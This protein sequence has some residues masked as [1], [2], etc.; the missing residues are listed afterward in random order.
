MS[1]KLT[2]CEIE[3]LT[4]WI[5]AEEKHGSIFGIP[6]EL[7]FH[8][9]ASDPFRLRRY[10]QILETPIG[11]AAGPH[12][13][14]SQNII[15]AWLTGARY[16]ELKT[17]QVLDE[18]TVTKPCIDMR[19]EGYNCEW[20]QE[21]KLEASYSEYLNAWIVLHLLRHRFFGQNNR[22]RGFIFNLSVGYNLEG[23]LSPPVQLF[24]DRMTDCRAEKTDRIQRLAGIYPA[25]AELEI[26]D[27][28][29]DNITIST[30]HGCPP[31]E[32][33]KI[34][35]YF[36]EERRLN[37]TIKLNPTLLGADR[38]RDIL[39]HRLGFDIVVPDAAFAHDPTFDAGVDLIRN[40][41]AS[42][43]KAGVTFN[44]KL[45][46]TLETENRKGNLPEN[47]KMLYMSGRALHAISI[48]LAARLQQ[49]FDGQLD[50]SFSAGVDFQNVARVLACGLSP[51][52]VCTDIL[53]PG[54]YGRLQ[55][56][57]QEIRRSCEASGSQSLDGFILSTAGGQ[58]NLKA[59]ALANLT[60]YAA[61]VTENRVYHR[62]F[63]PYDN[64]KTAREL[65]VFDC[66]AAPCIPTC[67]TG[68]DI[69]AYMRYTA[70]GNYREAYRVI[71][72]T[73]PFP[74]VQGK[75]CHAPCRT[76]CTRINLDQP[77][78][79]REIKRFIADRNRETRGPGPRD[80]LRTK[81]AIIGSGPSGLSCA[82]FLALAGFSVDVFEAAPFAGGLAADAIPEFR[83]DAASLKRD[84][85]A[86][87]AL[88]VRL[89][90]DSKIDH[91]RFQELRRTFDVLYIAVG[92][93]EPL[94]LGIPGEDA[95]GVTDQLSFLSRIRRG[96]TPAMGR[97]VVVIGGGNAAMDAA[98]TA[99]R[100]VGQKGEVTILYRRTRREMP[101][102]RE[103]I[104]AAEDEGIRLV[105]L[106]APLRI[107]TERGRVTAIACNHMK[108]GEPDS[109]GRRRPVP[110]EGATVRY[111]ADSVIPA[112]GQKVVLDFFPDGG[113]IIDP[114]TDR[115]QL[116]NVFAG[117]DAVRG[118]STLIEAIG[119]GRRIAQ[120][121]VEYTTDGVKPDPVR[122]R[123][124]NG[125]AAYQVK[126]AH[127][128]FGLPEDEI[129]N[130]AATGF[131]LTTTT[132]EETVARR[133]ASRCLSC[134][135][136]CAICTTVCPNR[137]N[138]VYPTGK[139][140]L[141]L[142]LVRMKGGSFSVDIT[143][144]LE[145]EESRQILNIGDFCNECG[146]CTTFCPTAGAPY[147]TKPRF[148]LSRDAFE[149]EKD[150]YFLKDNML[151]AKKSGVQTTMVLDRGKLTYT[152]TEA[153]V[154]MDAETLT[155]EQVRPNADG[156]Q[157]I[158]LEQAAEMAVLLRSLSPFYLFAPAP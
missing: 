49:A 6:R 47:E 85:D 135:L 70:A 144:R 53:K 81:A 39:N 146:S 91:Q 147:R 126:L 152:T 158:H 7:F 101:A 40:L 127:R 1:D 156:L 112:I 69:P 29:S 52:T 143:G 124:E 32:I 141:P 30:M 76:K 102:E 25:I 130:C 51:V 50:I 82:Y 154:I 19:D 8:P 120:K 88:G 140:S 92:A 14:L 129:R 95:R 118:A 37:T 157:E 10:D 67:P 68:Q 150:A 83:L 13:Q 66:T 38:T 134:D 15:A 26:P 155:V 65:T 11:V 55:Q 20:S 56:Y 44:I 34:G 139:M 90:T 18:L 94:P 114:L 80:S 142:Q 24:L 97:Q 138:V 57:L 115:T 33:E 89:H 108:L 54:G 36:I 137:A 113:L 9:A 27:R 43:E 22:E 128:E 93:Q 58:A 17:V 75:V 100:I 71:R 133:E 62:S 136:F 41:Q 86:I 87:L 59:A 121:I 151:I 132:L 12:S 99:R 131:Q 105:E 74:N 148:C 4:R 116:E 145:I 61:V 3:T 104:A 149:K 111:P 60:A 107:L 48:N 103:E 106:V 98:R 79:I 16:M 64:I 31:D 117:G 2:G 45:T 119:D 23:I 122:P 84:I 46:N 72:D 35:R 21:L 110:I 123:Q 77:L 78:A 28:I 73:N 5:L 125:F 42:A 109:S 96:E 63:F 153:R